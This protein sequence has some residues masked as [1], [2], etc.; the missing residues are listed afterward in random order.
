MY[1]VIR[2]GNAIGVDLEIASLKHFKEEV[3]EI[4]KGEECGIVFFNFDDIEAGDVI[5]SYSKS[6]SI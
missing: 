2:K 1:K 3:N 4:K 6:K 5:E